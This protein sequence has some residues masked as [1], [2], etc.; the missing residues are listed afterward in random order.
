MVGLPLLQSMYRLS[1]DDVVNYWL[2]NPYWQ[3]LCGATFFTHEKPMA[4]SGLPKWRK[5]VG[6][7]S[8]NPI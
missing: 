3:Y 5:R 8:Q 2:E 1:E 6:I 4:R 7:V